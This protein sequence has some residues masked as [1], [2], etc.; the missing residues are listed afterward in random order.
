MGEHVLLSF[1]IGGLGLTVWAIVDVLR[2]RAWLWLVSI[3]LF[4]PVGLI[5]WFVAGRRFHRHSET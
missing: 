4:W 5:A 2:A 3:I 1:V